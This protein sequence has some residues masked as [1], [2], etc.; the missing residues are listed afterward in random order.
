MKENFSFINNSILGAIIGDCLGVPVEFFSRNELKKKPVINMRG[1][2]THNRPK[3]TWSDDTAF[4]LATLDGLTIPFDL[5]IIAENFVNCYYHD[6]YWQKSLFDIGQG[7]R[8]GIEN[9]YEHLASNNFDEE[10][11]YGDIRDGNGSLMRMLPIVLYIYILK[12]SDFLD[13]E[14]RKNFVYKISALTHKNKKSKLACHMYVEYC[15]FLLNGYNKHDAYY[16]LCDL[17]NEYAGDE[18]FK[19]LLNKRLHKVKMKKISSSGYVI[20]SLI[21]SLW[22]FLT[23]TSY[24]TTVLKAVNLG[25]DTDTIAC[26][27]G[28]IAGLYYEIEKQISGLISDIYNIEKAKCIIDKFKEKILSK[29][30]IN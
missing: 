9:I 3:G 30:I 8:I 11:E 27:S 17:F 14:S 26:I 6:E 12:D 22:C 5:K 1:N 21:A 7:T 24:I 25:G 10:E 16:M 29:N 19:I 23:E 2:G 18:E 15:L 20:D 4:I 28:G 13:F